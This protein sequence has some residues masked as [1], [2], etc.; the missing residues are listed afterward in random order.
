MC[1]FHHYQPRCGGTATGHPRGHR[2]L[3]PSKDQIVQVRER[4]IQ[5][6]NVS[7]LLKDRLQCHCEEEWSKW[8]PLLNPNL[9]RDNH[10]IKEQLGG[11]PVT[12]FSPPGQ[13]GH[14][15]TDFPQES[16]STV[17]KAFSEA[18]M[19]TSLPPEVRFRSHHWRILC[20]WTRPYFQTP[21]K[22]VFE[23]QLHDEKQL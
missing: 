9:R 16:L 10:T 13:P 21:I 12:P 1:S 23:C 17:L 11:P 20:L 19:K 14:M 2:A 18:A 3:L 15:V 6:G 8:V 22:V 7:Q 4:E 5:T